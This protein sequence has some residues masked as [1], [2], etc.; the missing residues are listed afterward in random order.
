[1]TTAEQYKPLG[2]RTKERALSLTN[3]NERDPLAYTVGDFCRAMGLGRATVYKMIAKG[4]IQTALIGHRK[5]I[6][7]AIAVE[8][9]DRSMVKPSSAAPVPATAA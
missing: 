5:L 9:L 6:P 1:M 4:E 7:H 8:L 2:Q 3:L